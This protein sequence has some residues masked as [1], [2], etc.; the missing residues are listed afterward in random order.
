MFAT[1]QASAQDTARF[2]ASHMSFCQNGH[3][4]FV[5]TT[6]SP[7]LSNCTFHWDFGAWSSPW[8]SDSMTPPTVTYGN[9]G[10]PTVTL[11]VYNTVTHTYSTYSMVL[12]V[13]AVPNITGLLPYT[14]PMLGCGHDSVALSA[15]T[16]IPSMVIWQRPDLSRDTA[17]SIEARAIGYYTV[18]AMSSEGCATG[19]LSVI[20]VNS[21]PLVTA[22]IGVS[23]MH[24]YSTDTSVP[25]C[26]SDNP[27]IN[28]NWSGGTY[29]WTFTWNTGQTSNSFAITAT[30][31]YIFTVTDANGCTSKDTTNVIVNNGPDTSILSSSGSTSCYGDT[32]TLTATPG[33]V[34]YFWNNG[35]TTNV[36]KITYGGMFIATITDSNGCTSQTSPRSII[37]NYPPSPIAIVDKC[38]MGVSVP[39][40]GASYQWYY[41]LN[42]IIGATSQFY[43]T[44]IP[45]FYSVQEHLGGC[46]GMSPRVYSECATGIDNVANAAD[47]KVYPNPFN[48]YINIDLPNGTH[49]IEITDILGTKILNKQVIGSVQVPLAEYSAGIYFLSI[50]T[51]G[52]D[53]VHKQKI[54]KQ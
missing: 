7:N 11:T 35:N 3:V 39:D 25:V 31:R 18:T 15:T 54:V 44:S 4:N 33:Y 13:F 6:T 53:I 41:E 38:D 9:A 12:T 10:A 1:S 46:P 47:I 5:N 19:Y 8:S 2:T 24:G 51:T 17:T 43:T 52:G 32:V 20:S 49:N 14:P 27:N 50:K 48:Q 42:P 16:S 28:G 30:Q 45:G 29:P 22:T 21:Y 40:A 36:A 34:S 26:K 23:S 37:F